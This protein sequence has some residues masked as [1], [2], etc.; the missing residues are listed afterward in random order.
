MF[1]VELV[2]FFFKQKTAYEML[3]SLVGSE[4]CIRD[5]PTVE[6]QLFL[7]WRHA[8]KPKPNAKELK[9]AFAFFRRIDKPLFPGRVAQSLVVDA[10]ASHGL[11]GLLL[12]AY[13]RAERVVM[14][15]PNQPRS[16]HTM[17]EAWRGF[18]PEDAEVIYDQR[19]LGDALGGWL[20][21]HAPGEVSVV[22]VHAC[23]HLSAQIVEACLARGA[24]FAVMPCCHKD[25]Q[26]SMKEAAKALELPL[27]VVMDLAMVGKVQASPG[28][29]CKLKTVD[30]EITPQNRIIIGVR[31]DAQALGPTATA[32][33]QEAEHKMAKAYDRAHRNKEDPLVAIGDACI[34]VSEHSNINFED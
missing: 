14:V 34:S 21:Q 19:C 9:E 1:V 31:N 12:C 23:Q 29:L 4:M 32:L 5:S 25:H 16:Y 24:G 8:P 26:G 28:Y 2:F 11:V 7:A 10:C 20:E 18:I 15:D 13:R 3:R 33:V 30:S 22:G 6:R 17:R 27:G